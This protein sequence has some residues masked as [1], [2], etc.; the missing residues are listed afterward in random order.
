VWGIVPAA[1]GSICSLFMAGKLNFRIVQLHLTDQCNLRCSYCYEDRAPRSKH[2]MSIATAQQ[3]AARHLT[4]DGSHESIEFDFIGGEPLLAWD[5]IVSLVEFVHHRQWPRKW[6]FSLTTN[7]TLFT[8]EIKQWL[9][10]HSCVA[11]SLSIDGTRAAHDKNRCGSYSRMIEHVPWV[12][13]RSARFKMEPR[14]KMTIGPDTI[15]MMAEGI[16]ELHDMGFAKIDS[17]IPY[18]NIWG[19]RLES[20]LGAF[21]E[22]LDKIV[23]YYFQRPHLQPSHLVDLPL[24]NM[25]NK[26]SDKDFPRWCGSGDPMICYD[27]EGRA[28]PCH[29]FAP[30]SIG[31]KYDGPLMFERKSWGEVNKA[32]SF[33]CAEC[34]FV[35]VCPSCMALNWLENGDVDRRTRWHCGFILLQMKA[36]AKL[37]ILRLTRD[38]AAAPSTDEGRVTVSA[39]KPH[40][41]H[42]LNVYERFSGNTE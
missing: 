18:E 17:N 2:I 11:F 8:D 3:V 9:D 34:P 4:E 36:T 29:R 13:E 35:A 33:P 40:L 39:L 27:V 5:V 15:P 22:Q 26:K 42:A 32:E 30:V 19:D 31:S 38:I 1:P 37:N 25:I 16:A 41:D 10:R 6:R 20:S 7:G 14:A 24:M 12:L 21:A 23:D 28:L